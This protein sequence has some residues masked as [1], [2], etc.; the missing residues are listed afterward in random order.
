VHEL[1][2]VPANA[3]AREELVDVFNAGY[4]GYYVP[5]QLDAEALD[6]HLGSGDVDLDASRVA[7]RAARPVGFCVLGVRGEEGWIGGMGVAPSERQTGVGEALM[8]DVLE[9]ARRRG[10]RRV[11]LEVLEQNDPA[12]RLYEKLGFERVRDLE[13]WTLDEAR[14]GEA[15]EVPREEAQAW[16]RDRR[17]EVEPWQRA[18]AT[19]AHLDDVQGLAVDGGAALVRV[20]N[21]RVSL[22][23]A[24]AED[25][26]AAEAL[27]AAARA[28]GDTLAVLNLP[29]DH[30]L[31]PALRTLGGTVQ[32]RQLELALEL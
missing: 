9:E 11:V 12:R 19:L 13:I 18:D 22:L 24:A 7:L 3:L 20:A 14:A 25:G 26:R 29:A 5:V 8:R 32:L 2:V 23:Q 4:E 17:T 10:L 1:T 15:R 21:G 28:R 6:R 16:I 27:I 30:P 31:A